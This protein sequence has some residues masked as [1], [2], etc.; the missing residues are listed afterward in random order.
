M[1]PEKSFLEI[2]DEKEL[3]DRFYRD[4]EFGTAG[5]R[6]IMGAG[7]NRMNVYTVGRAAQGLA[8][9]LK[10]LPQAAKAGV[11]VAFDSRNRSAEFALRAALI[12]AANGIKAHLFPGL[13][14]APAFLRRGAS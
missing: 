7:S 11:A 6:G 10:S 2:T 12:L 3:A 13:R 4:L 8:N 9:H 5:L 14:A 1:R